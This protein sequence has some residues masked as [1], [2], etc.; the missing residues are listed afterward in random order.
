VVA[1]PSFALQISRQLGA[2]VFV[3]SG[4]EEKIAR[5]LELGAA[6]G[7]IYHDAKWGGAYRR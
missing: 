5:A 6:G 3:T 4:S 2:Q 7:A 1:S